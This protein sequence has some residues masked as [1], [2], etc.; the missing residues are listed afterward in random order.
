MKHRVH[1]AWFTVLIAL[2]VAPVYGASP[3][4]VSGMVRDSGGVPQIGAVVQLLR[5]DLRVV[6]TVYTNSDGRFQFSSVHPGHYALKA[7]AA[8]FLPSLR[9]N[10]RVR[11]SAIVNLTLNTLF[12]A[13]QWLPSQPRGG[14]AQKDDWA[15]TLRSAADRPLLRW[16]EN[17]PLVVVSDG[18]GAKP[19]LKAR[20]MATGAAGAF[21]ED[22]E[23]YSA[24]V[25]STPTSSRELLA[26]VDF[27]PDTTAGMESMLGFEQDLGM[28]GSV[29]SVAAVSIHP[30]MTSGQ[31]MGLDAAAVR[32]SETMHFG[33]AIDAQ[34]GSTEVLARMGGAASNSLT[35][36]LPYA[37]VNFDA[38]DST[39]GYR[40]ATL[41]P[42]PQAMSAAETAAMP[43]FSARGGRL[44][45]ERGVHQEIAWERRTESSGM[46][47]VLYSDKIENPT[48][49][50]MSQF[51]AGGSFA[52]P[53]ENAA[54]LDGT[55]GLI[56]AGGPSFSSSGVAASYARRLP[57]GNDVRLSYASGEA[58]VM[59]ALPESQAVTM[60]QAVETA[61]AQRAETY[62]LS[63]SGTL[64]GTKTRWR[65]SYRWQ[66]DSTVTAVAPYAMN[67]TGPYLNVYVR[68]PIRL[69]GNG[70]T[71]FE[72]L[73]DVSNLLA[74]GYRP[75]LLK[76]GS[77]LIFAQGQRCIRGGLAFTF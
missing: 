50:A 74:E 10:V 32:S 75:F 65:A 62:T 1:L 44:L 29:Q 45:L 61:H 12:E 27:A 66:P 71:G 36:A 21:G 37:Q 59:P 68:Q 46:A 48:L 33:P 49:E 14:D 31:G 25:E 57:G 3:A 69:G 58:L 13:I 34:V 39:I 9:E 52:A 73:I 77:V 23:R 20:I 54:L 22:G 60:E 67:A 64:D 18:S 53:V 8:S 28:A 2:G 11:S 30:E 40:M 76:D 55:S 26:R 38:G 47:V 17:G 24:A 72:A 63:F 51:G 15:W 16:L 41:I 7:M 43:E 35:A 6:A 19:K 70:V 42:S 4:S 56:H 5:P